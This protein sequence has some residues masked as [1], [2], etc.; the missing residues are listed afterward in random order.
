[1]VVVLGGVL[2]LLLLLLLLLVLLLLFL[3]LLLP[4]WPP[5]NVEGN[6]IFL[7]NSF[8]S[9]RGKEVAASAADSVWG[10]REERHFTTPPPFPPPFP[11]IFSKQ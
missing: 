4:R 5:R 10:S 6:F 8:P 9:T 3:L 2:L 7:K 1:M 11:P